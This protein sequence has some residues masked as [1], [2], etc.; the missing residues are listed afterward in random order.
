MA[1]ATKSKAKTAKDEELERIGRR[2]E[3]LAKSVLAKLPEEKRTEVAIKLLEIRRLIS[4][5]EH[6]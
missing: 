2:V 5:D 3:R 4:D 1:T 6:Q